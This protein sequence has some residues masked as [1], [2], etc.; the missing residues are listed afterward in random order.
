MKKTTLIPLYI[1]YH[2]KNK[3]IIIDNLIIQAT[4]FCKDWFDDV[5]GRT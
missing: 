5:D 3:V 4:Y 2:R 1:G